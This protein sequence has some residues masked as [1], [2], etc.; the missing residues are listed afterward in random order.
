[1]TLKKVW[2]NAVMC[3]DYTG[4]LLQWQPSA[5]L[6]TKVIDANKIDVLSLSKKN[7]VLSCCICYR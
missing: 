3:Y 2:R 6:K 7:V 5:G 4:V 1:M